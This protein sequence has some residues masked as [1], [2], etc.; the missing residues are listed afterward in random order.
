MA[1]HAIGDNSFRMAIFIVAFLFL[2]SSNNFISLAK[3][4]IGEW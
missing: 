1:K 4:D 2:S 3:G